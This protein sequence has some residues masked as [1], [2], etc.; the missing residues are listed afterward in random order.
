M[1]YGGI[2]QHRVYHMAHELLQ[3]DLQSP[4]R[5]CRAMM[6]ELDIASY[7]ETLRKRSTPPAAGMDPLT[8]VDTDH[9]PQEIIFPKGNS[10]ELSGS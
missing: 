7:L 10:Y 4:G 1:R 8:L 9:P 2:F 5:I 6:P 3:H